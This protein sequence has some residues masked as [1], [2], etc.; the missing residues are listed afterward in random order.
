MCSRPH[1]ELVEGRRRGP[2]LANLWRE[3]EGT[4]DRVPEDL[5]G[6]A[7]SPTRPAT[8]PFPQRLLELAHPFVV[9]GARQGRGRGGDL[10]PA[11]ATAPSRHRH[12]AARRPPLPKETAPT[13]NA[14]KHGARP[15]EEGGAE[16]G[17]R[18][19]GARCR[20]GRG[21]G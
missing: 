8:V 17:R 10:A 21:G 19:G 20:A 18:G 11:T 4:P 14:G 2:G 13:C 3:W 7:D 16:A 5:N 6:A 9:A 12:G 1:P 15:P